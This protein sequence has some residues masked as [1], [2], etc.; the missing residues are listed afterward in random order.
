MSYVTGSEPEDHRADLD[1]L[2][3]QDKPA[4]GYAGGAPQ[5]LLLPPPTTPASRPAT[6][7][8]MIIM[9]VLLL[10]LTAGA[11]GGMV[12]LLQPQ[13]RTAGPD[14]REPSAAKASDASQVGRAGPVTPTHVKVGCQAPHA[15]DGA[16]RPVSYVPEQLIDGKLNTAWR[17]NGNGI[18]QVVAFTLP[19]GTSI[20]EVGLVNGYAKVDPASG[21]R[22]YGEYRR[23]TQVT[24]TFANGMSFQQSLTDGV[25]TLQ[26]LSI[27]AQA[28]DTVT[29]TINASTQPGSTSRGR[30]AVLISEVS[31]RQP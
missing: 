25:K 18:G 7:S 14:S 10:C 23:I 3:R 19:T 30:D 21:A 16:G 26:K 12:L 17:C 20:A 4:S 31:F 22:R 27:P 1:W 28:G 15:T 13:S 24:W 6:R 9:I 2:Y 11:V 8:P 5:T 29:L